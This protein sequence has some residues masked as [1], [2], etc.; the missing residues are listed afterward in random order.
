M[1]AAQSAAGAGHDGHPTFK[2]HRHLNILPLVSILLAGVSSGETPAIVLK[3]RHSRRIAAA[4]PNGWYGA[5]DAGYHTIDGIEARSQNTGRLFE[6][7]AD[8]SWAGFARLGYRFNENWRVELE[9]GYRDGGDISGITSPQPGFPSGVCAPIPAAGVCNVPEGHVSA[10]TF[11]VNAIYDFG[12]ASWAFRPFVGLGAGAAII[13]TEFMGQQGGNRT[14]AIGADDTS[15]KL[16]AQALAGVAW[17]VGDRAHV[18]LTYRY[19]MSNFEFETFSSSAASAQ[20][21]FAGRY[22]N[23]H[24]LTLGLRY[25]FGADE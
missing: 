7:E 23:S 19:L 8:D 24:T 17:A 16:A 12:D 13:D 10:T 3:W 4:E 15:T 18:D 21:P 14:V 20:G 11:M 25:A 5:V 6:I 1:F 22:D 9:G 2:T